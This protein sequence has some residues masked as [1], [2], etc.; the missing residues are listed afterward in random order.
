MPHAYTLRF[1]LALLLLGL[2]AGPVCAQVDLYTFAPRAST[3]VPL[4]AGATAVPAV[5]TDDAVSAVLPLGFSFVFDGTP[6]SQ[7][8]A[9]S[10]G[11]LSFATAARH[12]GSNPLL[13]GAAVSTEKPLVA[14]LWDDLGGGGGTASYLVSGTAPNR[15]FAFEWLNWKWR[16]TAQV[17]VIS[18]QARLFEGTN[19]IEFSYRPEAGV[20]ANPAAHIG[21]A[22]AVG[23]GAGGASAF[24]SLNSTGT[25]PMASSTVETVLNMSPAAGQVYAFTPPVPAA[26]PTPRNPTAVLTGTGATLSW[27]AV[28][29]GPFRVQYGPVGFNP[30][31]PASGTN[32]Y[33]TLS[34]IA[35]TSTPISGLLPTTQYQ[36]YVTQTCGGTAGTSLLSAAGSFT[37]LPVAGP[38]DD[39][40]NAILLPV[41]ATCASPVTGTVLGAT[42]SLAPACGGTTAADVWYRFIATGTAHT[43]TLSPLFSARM[44]V[45]AGTCAS[46]VMLFCGTV[47][48]SVTNPDPPLLLGGLTTGQTYYI[49]VY[50]NGIVPPAAMSTFTLCVTPGPANTP[51][52]DECANATPLTVGTTCTTPVAATI[53]NATQSLPAAYCTGTAPTSQARDVWFRFVAGGATQVLT[54]NTPFTTIVELRP[55]TCGSGTV[56]QCTQVPGNPSAASSFTLTNLVAGQPYRLRMF[57]SPGSSTVSGLAFTVCLTPGPTV[58]VNDECAAATVL[59]VTATCTTPIQGTVAGANL[60]AGTF[61]STC[62]TTATADVWYRFTATGASQLLTVSNQFTGSVNVRS[63]TCAASTSVWCNN[64]FT[65]NPTTYLVPGLVVG[66]TYFLRVT[67]NSALVPVGASATFTLCLNDVPPPPANDDCA[68]ALP[69][70][71]TMACTTPT[72]GTVASATLGSAGLTNPCGSTLGSD[73]WYRFTA[74]SPAQLLNFAPQFTGVVDVRSGTCAASTSIIACA[75]VNAAD[76]TTFAV[77]GLT[78]G[79]TYLVRVSALSSTQPVLGANAFFTLCLTNAPPAPANDDCAGAIAVPVQPGGCIGQTLGDLTS[80]LPSPTSLPRPSCGTAAGNDIWFKLV[81]PPSGI[82]TVRTVPPA[83]GSAVSRAWLAVYGG[84]CG[85]T[86]AELGC[87]NM[88]AGG[89]AYAEVTLIGRSA[90]ATLYVRVWASDISEFGP[91]AVCATTPALCGGPAALIA[92]TV[93]SRSVRLAWVPANPLATAA[94]YTV[95]Y[96]PVGFLPGAGTRLSG[97]TV[98]RF[99]LTGL[100]PDTDYCFYVR[101]DCG[102]IYGSSQFTGPECFHTPL[103]APANDEPCGAVLLTAA[104]APS[105][106]MPGSNMGAT[107]SAPP[108]LVLPAPCSPAGSPR[109]VWFSFTLPTG[110]TGVLLSLVGAP[111]GTVRGYTAPACATGPFALAFCLSARASN[112]ALGTVQINGLTPGQRYYV[113]VSGYGSSDTPGPFT[114]AATALLPSATRAGRAAAVLLSVSP[115]PSATGRLT[116][117][118]AAALAGPAQ[119]ELLNALGQVARYQTLPASNETSFDAS[120]LA[121]GVYTL[122][123]AAGAITAVQRVVLE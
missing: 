2:L 97:I 30:N 69:L 78:V 96:G 46:S 31:L 23:T 47:F 116:L 13:G 80:A 63:G 5:H 34:G 9:S 74:A 87:G 111:A 16:Y 55:G 85:G 28:G 122:R 95:D 39:C 4:G 102:G 114:I 117:H 60:S 99:H 44:E 81:V 33:V 19:R 18:F 50:G 105:P 108:G 26:C 43:I 35:G 40:A 91:V 65:G 59:P 104:F 82:I 67:C 118:R 56:L 98:P 94:S 3:F 15:V 38:N 110:A 101:Q 27:T 103:P 8:V 1:W 90:G 109:D 115:T 54:V 41:T 14:P 119:A 68:G 51:A 62:S 37:T 42:Q 120:G 92:D 57:L 17:A 49:R 53:A 84:T 106:P 100:L 32:V 112:R 113:A 76:N 107:A 70:P 83:G 73:V 66:Q 29:P 89:G 61:T 79:Q 6:Y 7:V 20:A 52:N 75:Y 64:I 11:F 86:L 36:F 71:V 93:Q 58:P 21:L 12:G 121:A 45:R 25:A 123:V 88:A 10:N 72:Q 22:G 77:P 24:L 48:N